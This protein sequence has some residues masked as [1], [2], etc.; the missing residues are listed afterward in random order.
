L[1]L[2]TPHMH[3][4]RVNVSAADNGEWSGLPGLLSAPPKWR[5]EWFTDPV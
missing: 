3:R 1:S 4:E 2:L 5:P